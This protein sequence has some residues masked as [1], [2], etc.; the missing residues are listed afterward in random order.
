[1]NKSATALGVIPARAH[2]SRFPFKVIANILGKPMIQYVWENAQRCATLS[3]VVVATDH[4]DIVRVVE[5]FGGK[6][7]MT[8]TFESGSDRVAFLARDSSEE[9]VVNLQADEPLLNP[10]SIDLLVKALTENPQMDIAT[11]AVCSM[12]T[13]ALRDPHTV[14][15]VANSRGEALYFSRAALVSQPTGAFLKHIGIYAFRKNSLLKFC[16]LPPSPLEQSEKLEQ[17]RALENG[18]RIQVVLV[19]ESS[20]AVDTPEDLEKVEAILRERNRQ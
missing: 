17:L 4:A 19:E 16:Q 1:M 6:S 3:R 20:K 18:M 14:K 8:P 15:V 12:S 7:V 9:I 2:S 5:S 10:H 11:L 13:E